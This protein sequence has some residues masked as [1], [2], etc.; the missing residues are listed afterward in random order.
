MYSCNPLFLHRG[1]TSEHGALYIYIS[2]K[3][4]FMTFIILH[5]NQQKRTLSSFKKLD[6]YSNKASF[7]RLRERPVTP[8]T[9]FFNLY[10]ISSF[11]PRQSHS[12]K[13][14]YKCSH[15]CDRLWK[16]CHTHRGYEG[17][18]TQKIFNGEMEES[19]VLCLT[20]EVR[21][22]QMPSTMMELTSGRT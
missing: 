6:Y 15:I 19:Q 17:T 7:P 21:Q 3:P 18:C 1:R 4:S 16:E 5:H 22:K 11:Y 14:L 10:P 8:R 12:P 9:G 2:H 13:T 20:C